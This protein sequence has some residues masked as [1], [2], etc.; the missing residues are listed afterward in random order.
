MIVS[1]DKAG[2]ASE[3]RGVTAEVVQHALHAL[4]A[5]TLARRQASKPM[6]A[7]LIIEN[8]DVIYTC[9]GPAPRRGLNQ[10]DATPVARA[11]IASWQGVSS[12]SARPSSAAPRSLSY[13]TPP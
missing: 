2:E 10:R 12:M 13:R 5:R 8:A 3:D 6:N 9:A 4:I 1:G 7:D 11:S